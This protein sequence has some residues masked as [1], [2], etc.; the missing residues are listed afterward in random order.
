MLC[1]APRDEEQPLVEGNLVEDQPHGEGH[2]VNEQD[3][4]ARSS[5]FVGIEGGC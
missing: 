1:E 2:P 3:E 5:E 4:K